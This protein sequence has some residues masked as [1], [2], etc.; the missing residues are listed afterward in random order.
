MASEDIDTFLVALKL[1]MVAFCQGH[2][3]KDGAFEVAVTTDSP[4]LD[5]LNKIIS[6]PLLTTHEKKV[7]S[8]VKR[9][10]INHRNMKAHGEKPAN[11]RLFGEAF[12][13]L[14][15]DE[16][17]GADCVARGQYKEPTL[18]QVVGADGEVKEFKTVYHKN[19][20]EKDEEGDKPI[21]VPGVP[22]EAFEHTFIAELV[23]TAGC[24]APGRLFC[25]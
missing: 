4:I 14:A 23:N 18:Y 5:D 2:R 21:T 20:V 9:A 11:G 10:A 24:D 17:V 15:M 3:Y 7:F 22:K 25:I 19:E 16:L 1:S 8:Q 12:S 13:L 6:S